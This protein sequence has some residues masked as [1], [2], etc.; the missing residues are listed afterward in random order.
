[1]N[2]DDLFTISPTALLILII[3]YMLLNPEKAEKWGSIL[4]RIFA[5]VNQ[6]AEL[7]TVA[8]DIQGEIN[9]FSKKMQKSAKGVMPYGIKINWVK[10]AEKEA[11]IKGNDVVVVMSKHTNQA[12]NLVNTCMAYLSVGLLPR[13]RMYIE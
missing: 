13:A 3:I 8:W 7:R 2:L 10:S 4:V 11:F 6:A 5:R 12:R 1:M 9:E